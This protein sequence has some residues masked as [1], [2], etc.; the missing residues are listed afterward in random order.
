[1]QARTLR[2]LEDPRD[3]HV[4]FDATENP[5]APALSAPVGALGRLPRRVGGAPSCLWQQPPL[6]E[7]TLGYGG[8]ICGI[9]R[10]AEGRYTEL[11]CVII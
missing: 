8:E 5:S 6:A 11:D 10:R 9:D 2:G 4:Y 3:Y 1:M 7:G